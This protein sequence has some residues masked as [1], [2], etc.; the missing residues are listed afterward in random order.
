MQKEWAPE[1]LLLGAA[2]GGV[3]VA[4]VTNLL[5]VITHILS[6]AFI[7]SVT[8]E[9]GDAAHFALVRW[10]AQS[11]YARSTNALRVAPRGEEYDG[12]AMVRGQ[13]EAEYSERRS[14]CVFVVALET[15]R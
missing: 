4:T 12:S 5:G 9:S 14:R 1:W 10:L 15:G 7:A 2:A 6:R 13:V 8:V 11:S 3:L